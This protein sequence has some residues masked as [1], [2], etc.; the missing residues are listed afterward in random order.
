MEAQENYDISTFRL[1]AE[2][3]AS[4]LLSHIV[5][6]GGAAPSSHRRRPTFPCDQSYV[7]ILTLFPTYINEMPNPQ[8][9]Q[10]ISG[11]PTHYHY[12]T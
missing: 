4:E 12:Y 11:A 8:L 9:Y 2:C 6:R 1:T 3:S 7:S 10:H 5:G